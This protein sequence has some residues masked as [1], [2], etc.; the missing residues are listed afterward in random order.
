LLSIKAA[1]KS[2]LVDKKRRLVLTSDKIYIFYKKETTPR[3]IIDYADIM[4]VTISLHPSTKSGLIFHFATKADEEWICDKRQ[5]LV[6]VTAQQYTVKTGK[7]IDI[8][9]INSN[10]LSVYLTTERDLQRKMSRMPG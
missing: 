10:D 4:G 6:E 3:Y 5:E 8:Y 7:S 1:K 9:G 2:F